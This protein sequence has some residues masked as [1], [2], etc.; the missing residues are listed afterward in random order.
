ADLEAKL[1]HVA[2]PVQIPVG[3]GPEFSGVI[4]LIEMQLVG[5]EGE[6]GE[7]VVLSPI[8][9][10][11]RDEADR[12]R[13][14]MLDALSLYDDE[15]MEV[16]LEDH[17]PSAEQIHAALRRATL[18]REITPVLLGT[19]Y[20]NKGV[21][22]LLDAVARYLPSPLDRVAYAAD[23]HNEGAETAVTADP[24][25]PVVAMAFKIVDEPF[26]QVTYT[27]IYRG[28]ITKGAQYLNSRTGKK[29]RINRI[30]RIH[31]DDREDLRDARA[32]DIVALMGVDCASGDTLCDQ[33]TNLSL[34][35]MHTAEPVVSLAIR[36]LKSSD[37]DA[38]SK[39]LNRFMKEDP[40]FHVQHDEE[41]G[42]TIIAGMGELHLEVYVERMLREYKANVE[43]GRPKVNYREAPMVESPYNY[44]HKKQ[45]GGSGQFAHV[46]GRMFP[47]PSDTE[48]D[49]EFESKVRGGHVPTEYISS[50]DKGFQIARAKGPLA[51]FEIIN[52]RM[53]LEDGSS[54]A[55][56][57]SDLA[58]QV[59]AREA[60]RQAFLASKPALLEPVMKVEI[61]APTEFQGSVS[62]EV[63]SRRGII[64]GT[65][66]KG[67]S[68]VISAEVPLANMFGYATDLRSMTQGKA[69]FSMEFLCYRR[70]PAT[71]QDEIVERVRR[72]RAAAKR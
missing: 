27:R 69:T 28:T 12:A 24:D 31:A 43:V 55:V 10:G 40:T 67:P 41:S 8:P 49:Y 58:F 60:F 13:H 64:T 57:S 38:M 51:D 53:V 9:D 72:E 44:K 50:V 37:R 35:Q 62:G 61:E 45:T 19:A 14:G 46:I 22:C 4:D 20:R 65:E 21:Q 71:I 39:A 6:K 36:P 26:G 18:L 33:G 25:G 17:E 56:D 2:V 29:Q 1:G 15:L 30:L 16:M 23:N 3:L 52:V 47:L 70:V 11:L 66:M 34:E 32:G 5:F 59:C 63:S 42:D 68:T 7:R 48:H 54:H